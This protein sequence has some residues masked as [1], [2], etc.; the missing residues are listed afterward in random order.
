MRELRPNDWYLLASKIAQVQLCSHS[1]A[2]FQCYVPASGLPSVD[3][4][5]VLPF[6]YIRVQ[7]VTGGEGATLPFLEI[8]LGKLQR[9]ADCVRG[10]PAPEPAGCR[11]PDGIT[12]YGI[13]IRGRGWESPWSGHTS[14]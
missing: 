3:I 10:R 5:V 11:S 13:F 1:I 2:N 8:R 4:A 7:L 14:K 12:G 6:G 9:N